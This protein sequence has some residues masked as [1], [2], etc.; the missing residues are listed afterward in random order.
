MI[1]AVLRRRAQREITDKK[2]GKKSPEPEEPQ[3]PTEVLSE[4]SIGSAPS[5]KGIV[6]FSTLTLPAD[7]EATSYDGEY[8]LAFLDRSPSSVV[9]PFVPISSESDATVGIR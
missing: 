3:S 4:V 5:T 6:T 7:T 1:V 8:E 9:L 2:K